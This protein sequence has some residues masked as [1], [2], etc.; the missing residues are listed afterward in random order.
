SSGRLAGAGGRDEPRFG[1]PQ[2]PPMPARRRAP[3]ARRPPRRRAVLLLGGL[4]LAGL[5]ALAGG[6][7]EVASPAPTALPGT[8]AAPAQPPLDEEAR[9]SPLTPCTPDPAEGGHRA[10]P[11]RVAPSGPHLD[12]PIL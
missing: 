7:R 1:A 12:V 10:A 5:V 3:L 8:A 2:S 11:V 6:I 9:D 4:V